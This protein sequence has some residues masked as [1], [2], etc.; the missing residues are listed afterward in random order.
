MTQK[1]K[2]LLISL[3]CSLFVLFGQVSAATASP[4]IIPKA[5]NIDAKAY[6]LV[7][8]KTGAVLAE[9]NQNERLAPASLTKLM[10]LYITFQQLEKG[11][12]RLQDKVRI[13]KKA[14]QTGGSRMFLR[15]GATPTVEQLIQGVIV[16]SGNDATVALSEFIAGSEGAFVQMMNAQAQSLG[17]TNTN[18]MDAT[19]LPNPQHYSSA[20]D[21]AIL[22]RAIVRTFPQDY[23]Y[24]SQKW[25][26]YNNI[27]QPNRNRLLWRYKYADGLKTGHTSEAGF[28]LI[29][30]AQ[31]EGMRLISVVLGTPTDEARADDSQALL[32][33]GFRFF[34]TTELYQAGSTLANPRVY[35]GKNKTTPVGL[36]NALYATVPV[37]S[38][39]NIKTNQQ[40]QSPLKAPLK[41][42]QNVGTLTLTLDGKTLASAPLVT[43]AANPKGG[44]M[45]RMGDHISLGFHKFFGGKK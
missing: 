1:V 4:T 38:A 11:T 28:C 10:T 21:L 25:L 22:A 45:S 20:Q 26:T 31:K 40:I 24:F 35:F 37:G 19:G 8:V 13:S 3:F 36:E 5:P 2:A 12:I 33:Y 27:K 6:M 14:W 39:K 41:Q 15:E 7:D 32:T 9:K 44:F 29:A 18:F 16:D 42:G 23:H 34:K 17:M 30:S 43:L